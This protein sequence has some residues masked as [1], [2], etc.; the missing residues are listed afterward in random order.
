VTAVQLNGERR[1][2]PQGATLELA[3]RAAGAPE[4]GRGVAAALDGEVVPR[5]DWPAT[6]LH[7]GQHVEVLHAVQGG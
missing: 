5:A 7:D 3:V 6:R 2:L 4:D 1:E